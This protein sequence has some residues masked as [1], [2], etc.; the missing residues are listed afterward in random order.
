MPSPTRLSDLSLAHPPLLTAD[1]QG[2]G[3]E[4]GWS[5]STM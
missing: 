1:D 4:I 2:A 5:L 3:E